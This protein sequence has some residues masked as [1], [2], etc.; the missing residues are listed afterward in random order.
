[1]IQ[2]TLKPEEEGEGVKTTR[3]S[4]AG[5][6]NAGNAAGVPSVSTKVKGEKLEKGDARGKRGRSSTLLR[7][8]EKTGPRGKKNGRCRP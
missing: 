5:V 2:L 7:A 8:D 4:H 1:M 3:R 6:K